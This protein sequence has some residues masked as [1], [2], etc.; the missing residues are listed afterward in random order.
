MPGSPLPQLIALLVLPAV[1]SIA[2]RRAGVAT[3]ASVV[4]A[5]G[6]A[7]ALVLLPAGS[8][9]DGT[10]A[11]S[12]FGR[13]ACWVS[14]VGATLAWFAIPSAPGAADRRRGAVWTLHLLAVATVLATQS[15]LL[16]LLVILVTAAIIGR[17]MP[18]GGAWRRSL[19]VGG[20]LVSVGLM[21][22]RVSPPPMSDLAIAGTVVLGFLMVAGGFPFGAAILVWLHRA[23]PRVASAVATS[24]APALL[25]ALV[26]NMPRLNHLQLATPTKVA[27]TVAGFGAVT[28]L[29]AALATFA[30]HG[31]HDLA[32]TG[33]LADIGLA[34]V[35][36][37]AGGNDGAALAL[38]VL[39]I[40]RRWARRAA[41]G[42]FLGASGMPPTLG[43]PARLLVLAAAFRL[44]PGLAAIVL[45][46]V[47]L[48]LVASA[49]VVLAQLGSVDDETRGGPVRRVAALA[50]AVAL[51]LSLVGG[52]AP[53][54]VLSRVWGIG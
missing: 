17:L 26:D 43:F 9:F 39:A 11:I 12:A 24:I 23:G 46:G 7:I 44:S 29:G 48:G 31:W 30:V 34:M 18:A 19:A 1:A 35:A 47:V 3:I 6:S 15:P 2:S 8:W 13:G 40:R 53:G 10:M 33:V 16:L 32:A 54:L 37:G 5:G 22:M 38:M 51:L 41:T 45:A 52:V 14:L 28:L 20:L 49:R 50:I 36:V 4:A 42:A 25:A 21:A 27:I